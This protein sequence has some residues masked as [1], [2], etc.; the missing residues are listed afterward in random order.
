[1]PEHP[2]AEQLMDRP[3]AALG[4]HAYM[5]RQTPEELR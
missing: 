5:A 3:I 1:M 4:A 2:S